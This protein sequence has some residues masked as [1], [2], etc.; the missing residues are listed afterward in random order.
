VRVLNVPLTFINL[1][2]FGF[3]GSGNSS[4]NLQSQFGTG[5][6]TL[7]YTISNRLYGGFVEY[8]LKMGLLSLPLVTGYFYMLVTIGKVNLFLSGSRRSVGVVF[9]GMLL[10]LSLQDGSLASPL[11]I[12]A[13]V[14]VFLQGKV[15]LKS[16]RRSNL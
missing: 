15:L 2:H 13:V 4:F 1:S 8:I 12:F 11:M 9:S 6:G 14:Y 3:W 7:G 5:F 10:L 16:T